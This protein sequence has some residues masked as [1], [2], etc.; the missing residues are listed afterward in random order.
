MQSVLKAY[1]AIANKGDKELKD[2]KHNASYKKVLDA[3]DSVLT[4]IGTPNTKMLMQKEN[5]DER[6]SGDDTPMSMMV[7]SKD[8]DVFKKLKVIVA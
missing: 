4:M 7:H 8:L 5:L 3:R 1:Q 2:T 6:V